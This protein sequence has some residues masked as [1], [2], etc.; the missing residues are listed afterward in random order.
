ME[1]GNEIIVSHSSDISGECISVIDREND[2]D[3]HCR[4]KRLD[5][6]SAH[7][8]TSKSARRNVEGG[9]R[10]CKYQ[11]MMRICLRVRSV[12]QN[13]TINV[14]NCRIIRSRCFSHSDT[15]ICL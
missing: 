14:R 9:T 5:C 15:G 10:S 3:S 2:G 8:M 6:D 4:S 13:I 11:K 7:K 1:R 12:S